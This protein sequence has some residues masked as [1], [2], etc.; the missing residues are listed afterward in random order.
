[1]AGWPVIDGLLSRATRRGEAL[2]E[3]EIGGWAIRP[4]TQVYLYQWASHMNP[5]RF[6]RPEEFLPSRWTPELEA[7][8][9]RCAY[10]PFGG[11]P[12]VCI[13][14]HFAWAELVVTLAAALSRYELHP[15]KPF[16]PRL[17][18]SITAR[19]KDP[20]PMRV[21]HITRRVPLAVAR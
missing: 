9:P 19:P 3:L 1:M 14:N 2:E 17:L 6:E 13:G 7:S 12:R 20:I 4:S 21:E 8:L 10:T 5:V 11:G 16:R 18:L 15:V